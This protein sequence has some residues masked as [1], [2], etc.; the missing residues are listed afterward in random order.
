MGQVLT[1]AFDI[2]L[3]SPWLFLSI[4]LVFIPVGMLA[5]LAHGFTLRI[6]PVEPVVPFPEANIAQEVVLILAVGQLHFGL[7]YALVIAGTTAALA[8]MEI[9]RLTS[10][11]QAFATVMRRFGALFLSRFVAFL[12]VMGLAITVIGLPLALRQAVRWAF[13]EQAVLLDGKEARP[14]FAE[15]ASAAGADWWWSAG[16][17]VA[18]GLVG[19]AVAPALGIFLVIFLRSTP[20]AY[21]NLIASAI[22]VAIVPY[23][24]IALALVYFDLRSRATRASVG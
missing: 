16:A 9:D 15:S 2:Y 22:Y 17:I 24:A 19:L 21:V 18:L 1:S 8:A 5:S 11:R 4:G 23:V 10:V 3:R 6:S 20:V 14:A 7:A 12:V 13:L